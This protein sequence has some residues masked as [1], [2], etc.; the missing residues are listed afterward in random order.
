MFIVGRTKD[1][2]IRSG[3]NAYPIEV[4]SVINTHPSV[5]V[6]AVVGQPT[7]DGNEEVIAFVEIKDGEKF[8]A[9]ALHDYLVERLSPYKRPE[10]ILRVATIPTTAS[11]KLL[12]HQLRQMLAEQK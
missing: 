5:R 7:A 11:G 2:I 3:F 1:L 9:S 8:D 12:K 10:K 4:E 6:S